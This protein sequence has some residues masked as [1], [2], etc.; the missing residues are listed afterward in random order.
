[1]VR[2]SA[3][4]QTHLS[5]IIA[6]VDCYLHLKLTIRLRVIFSLGFFLGGWEI[7]TNVSERSLVKSECSAFSKHRSRK[8]PVATVINQMWMRILRQ[9]V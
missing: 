4:A 6:R 9:R 8:I 1:M 2:C 5:Q 3:D 7:Q